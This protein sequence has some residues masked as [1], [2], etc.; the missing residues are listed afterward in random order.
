MAATGN[1]SLPSKPEPPDFFRPARGHWLLAFLI[2]LLLFLHQEL[3]EQ[4][5]LVAS[6]NQPTALNIYVHA[7]KSIGDLV[8]CPANFLFRPRPK[9]TCSSVGMA[10]RRNSQI[11][12]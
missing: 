1:K 11:L 5:D 2:L 9:C 10:Q 8:Q 3:I 12:I 6:M 7:Q 4:Y